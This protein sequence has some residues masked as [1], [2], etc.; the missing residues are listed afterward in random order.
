MTLSIDTF[1][2]ILVC[3]VLAVAIT[4]YT[5]QTIVGSAQGLASLVGL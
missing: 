5:T 2:K 3:T 1:L 4:V